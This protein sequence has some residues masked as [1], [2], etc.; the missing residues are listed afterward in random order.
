M[1]FTSL[2][3]VAVMVAVGVERRARAEDEFER[4][5]IAYSAGAPD[6]PVERLRC[7]LDAGE[8][9]LAHAG[10]GGYL[11]AVLAALDVP[12]SS[13]TLV[14]SKTSLQQQ[15]ISPTNARALY[16]ND[17][18]YVGWVPGGEVVEFSVADPALGTVFYALDDDPAERPR[19]ERQTDDCLICHGGSQTRGVPGHV[20]RSVYPDRGGQ[21]IFSAGSHRVDDTTPFERR[22]GGWYVTG[23]HGAAAHLGNLTYGKRPDGEGPGAPDGLNMTDLGGRIDTARYLSP[24]SDLVAL[25]VLAHQAAA[26]NAITKASFDARTALHREESLNRELGEPAGTRWPSTETVLD[27]AAAALVDCFLFRGA[28]PLEAP[29]A[30]TSPFATEFAAAGPRDPRGRSLRDLDLETRLFRHPCSFLVYSASFAALPDD[31]KSRF[32]KRMDEVLS[33]RTGGSDFA[34]L[35]VADRAAIREIL[36]ATKPDA[37]DAWRTP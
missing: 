30:G 31:V 19:I 26:H 18:V 16:F 23:S 3:V 15:R 4:P 33:G 8:V 21:P 11:R 28:A 12:V 13:Q 29:I 27:G 34:H 9:T 20:I 2:A 5:P 10:R 24:H 1:R 17:D 22:W 25:T 6:N 36:A 37:P 35:T 14:F 7:R 32:W